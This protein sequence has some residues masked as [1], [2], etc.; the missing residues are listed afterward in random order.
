MQVL[1]SLRRR[2]KTG[3]SVWHFCHIS[4]TDQYFAVG[5]DDM[6]SIPCT[7]RKHLRQVYENF[8]RYGYASKLRPIRAKK[9]AP[10]ADPW[11]S[12]LPLDLQLQLDALAVA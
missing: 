8:K 11:D 1:S 7:D 4:E 3:V 9:S 2:T 10:I 6:K 12:K 5:G